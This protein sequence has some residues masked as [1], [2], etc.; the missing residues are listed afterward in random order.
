ML[1][2]GVIG[3]RGIGNQHADCYMSSPDAELV[4]VCDLVKERADE[5]A[6]RLGVKAYYDM[7]EMLQAEDLDICDV[8][9]GGTENGS[10][11]YA[12]VMAGL[13]AGC[14][15]LCEKPISNDIGEARE[16][17]A[18]AAE[19]NLCFGIN[20]NHRFCPPAFKAKEWVEEGRLGEV[21]FINMALWIGNPKD[22]EF[23]HLRALHP[24]SIDVM[25]YFCGS[26]EYVQ[27][28]L[29]RSEGRTCWSNASI[30]VKFENGIIGHLTGS[31][32]MTTRHPIERCEVA[33]TKARFVIDNVYEDLTLWEH[34]KDEVTNIHNP[35]FG[36][37]SG[38]HDTF[39]IRIHRFC[40]QVA[41]GADPED[42]EASGADGLQAQE[43]IE[44]AIQSHQTG[45]V[46][47]LQV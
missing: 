45:E 12:P 4:A 31:Y 35:I 19:E 7:N 2:V 39:R 42:I 10:D 13:D 29:K 18:K 1:T 41:A 11:H 26:I 32:D 30:N 6:D 44:A 27:A 9:T 8:S 43:V 17:V 3:M 34:E 14:H 22:D 46:V 5:A 15:V 37:L 21:N 47:K 40:E 33:G 16:M 24:H 23:F 28:F 36:G 20:L 38:F 25:R